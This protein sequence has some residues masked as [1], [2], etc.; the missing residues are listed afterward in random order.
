MRQLLI[1]I[2][3]IFVYQAAH[4]QKKATQ[5]VPQL[6]IQYLNERNFEKAAPLFRDLLA[7]GNSAY[8]R[9]YIQCLAELKQYQQAE[10]EIRKEIRKEKIPQADLLIGLGYVL[11]LQKKDD[12]SQEKYLEAIGQLAGNRNNIV[13]TAS[14]FIYWNEYEMAEKTYMRGQELLPGEKFYGELVNVYRHTQNYGRLMEA[15]M[16]MV[17][18]N[19]AQLP[20]VQSVLSSAMYLDFEN[21]L[22]DEFRTLILKRIQSE[23]DVLVFNRLLIW[24]FLQE[25][26]FT[27]ALRQSIALDRRTLR[28]EPEIINL[29]LTALNNR[30]YA[31]AINAF[32]YIL[33]KGAGSAF[34]NQA[35]VHKMHSEYMDYI[36]T[37]GRDRMR[38][39]L[40]EKQ[41]GKALGILGYKPPHIH[42]IR[43]YAHLLG[44]YLNMGDSARKILERGLSIPALRPQ[45]SGVLKSELGDISVYNDDPW[46]ATLVYSQVI[47]A[48]RDNEL[49]DE[50]KLKKAK[51]GYYLGNFS[52]AKAQL[53]VL[54]ASTSKLTA[55]DA[56]E[57]SLFISNNIEQDSLM[58]PLQYF[59][60]A[61]LLIFMNRDTQALTVLDSV[62]ALFQSHSLADDILFRR[63]NIE[64]KRNNIQTAMEYLGKIVKEYSNELI[65]DDALFLLAET[66]HYRLNDHERAAARYRDL[67]FSYPGSIYAT[68]ARDR[69]RELTGK[70]AGEGIKDVSDIEKQFF[71]GTFPSPSGHP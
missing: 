56:M 10:S 66:C 69:Y 61:D 25:K 44:F 54:K 2:I 71:H 43:E 47:D 42:L 22:R 31:D 51:L 38:G 27:A 1:I 21:G 63:A 67:L 9:Y 35:Y 62:M 23:P 37:G 26:Q 5:S 30:N 33:S 57:L 46:E 40:L 13:N 64:I 20:Y 45:E 32:D 65:A 48:N 7:N 3:T 41:F 58:Q 36:E 8:F 11:K 6:A 59:A 34:Y 17:R 15:L 16:E 68:L 53:D 18:L 39:E 12:E 4:C 52:W 24:F 60:R 19:E 50:A 28:E 14:L 49:G 70:T 55:N 29:A